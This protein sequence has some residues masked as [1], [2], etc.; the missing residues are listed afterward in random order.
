[1]ILSF[2]QI[3]PWLAQYK[4]LTLFPLTVIEGPIIT[5]VAGFFSSLGYLNIFVAY[6]VVV[7]GDLTGDIIHYYIGRIGGMDFFS[8]HRKFLGVGQEELKKIEGQFSKRGA[9]LLFIGKMSHGIGG[10]FL[11]AAGIIKMPFGKFIFSN[12]LATLLKSLILLLIGFYF[13]HALN[14]INTYL[15]RVALITTGVAILLVIIYLFYLKK[16]NSDDK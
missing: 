16:N 7:A 5:V 12:M 15:E 14:S 10:A 8:R 3:I 1:M 2:S 11:I 4:Y 9:K 13:G 6:L